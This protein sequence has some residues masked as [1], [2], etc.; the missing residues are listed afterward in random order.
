MV[1][2]GRKGPLLVPLTRKT[3]AAELLMVAASPE[4]GFRLG[5]RAVVGDELALQPWPA[6]QVQVLAENVA[7]VNRGMEDV[8]YSK[9]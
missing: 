9:Q 1:A 6:L 8:V 2:A 7:K 5:G 3:A 4:S